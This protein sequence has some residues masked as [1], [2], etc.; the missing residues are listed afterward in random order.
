LL[1]QQHTRI[2]DDD[3]DDA[4]LATTDNGRHD[5]SCRVLPPPR[6]EFTSHELWNRLGTKWAAPTSS[7]P[8]PGSSLSYLWHVP[9]GHTVLVA[10]AKNEWYAQLNAAGQPIMDALAKVLIQRILSGES[11]AETSSSKP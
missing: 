1:G 6:T 11:P 5:E 9:F 10:N 2:R 8:E 4:V 3:D 7:S